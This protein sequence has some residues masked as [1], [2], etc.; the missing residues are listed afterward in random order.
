M[1]GADSAW[2]LIL[3][4]VALT[5][6]VIIG[7]GSAVNPDWGIKHFGPSLR[8]GGE[9]LTEFNRFGMAFFGIALGAFGLFGLYSLLRDCF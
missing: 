9:L 1:C 5:S 7:V 3:G 4:I 8:R 2:K 6:F